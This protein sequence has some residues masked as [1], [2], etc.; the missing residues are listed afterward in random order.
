MS[1]PRTAG[2]RPSARRVHT[3]TST[4]KAKDQLE[5]GIRLTRG[6]Q[7]YE[8][9]IGDVDAASARRLRAT[10]GY[11]PLSL[12]QA[13]VNDPDVDMVA[14]W[15]WLCDIVAGRDTELEDIEVSYADI[16]DDRFDVDQAEP[17][18][19]ADGGVSLDPE[20]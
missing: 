10:T 4:Q 18:S 6:D 13:I 19:E 11:G 12:M 14:A 5:A 17:R 2:Q 3:R 1:N 7:V 16:F 15:I 20:A 9:R 8:L